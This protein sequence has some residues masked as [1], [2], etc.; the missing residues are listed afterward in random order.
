MLRVIAGEFKGRR[1]SAPKTDFCRPTL[2]RVK[3]SIFNVLGED[4][5][6]RSVLDLF[7]GTG[8]LGIEALSRGSSDCMFMDSSKQAIAL[9]KKNI[10]ELGLDSRAYF[11]LSDVFRFDWSSSPKSFGLVFADPP[12]DKR[13]GTM[14]VEMILKNNVITSKGLLIFERSR[15][16]KV[17]TGFLQLLKTL[18]F[19]QTEVDFYI[20]PE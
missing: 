6:D 11:I 16:E 10:S 8:S 19:G 9:A 18:R 5:V 13:V 7:C 14:L 4:V 3:E 17:E 20:R 12:Y 2:D 1:L 15:Q